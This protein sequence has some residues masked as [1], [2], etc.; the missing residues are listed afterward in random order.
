M[1]VKGQ[2]AA[3]SQVYSAPLY[4][5]PSFT[6]L[7][8]GDRLTINYRDQWSS[9]PGSYRTFLLSY[10]KFFEEYQ[11]GLGIMAFRDDAG[12]G[13]FV[14]QNVGLLYAYEFQVMRTLYVRPGLNFKMFQRVVDDS[15]RLYYNQIDEKTGVSSAG[16]VETKSTSKFDAAASVLLYNEAFWIGAGLD[17]IIKNDVSVTDIAT[18][19]PMKLS[20]Y[21]G[22]K[23]VYKSGYS[24]RE[25]QSIT[26]A[27]HY[28]K[29][30]VF[31]QLDMGTYWFINPIEL[32]LWY[33]GIPFVKSETGLTNNDALIF[34]MG[35]AVGPLRF[36]YSYD[37]TLSELAGTSGGS[38]EISLTFRFGQSFS[39]GKSPRGAIPCPGLGSGYAPAS[40]KGKVRRRRRIF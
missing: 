7:N 34:I 35:I 24:P 28:K 37:L 21:G 38:N 18:S 17:H 27:F 36:A 1:G 9:V 25:T 32:G 33:R 39:L 11:S 14:D 13:A 5:S 19:I 2:D 29:Q 20:I 8:F 31:N 22:S 3:F 30:D 10:D 16:G 15:D 4:L 6:G 40:K 26:L 23:I 12:G